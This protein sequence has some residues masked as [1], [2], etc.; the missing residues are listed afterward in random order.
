[1][2]KVLSYCYVYPLKTGYKFKKKKDSTHYCFK[3]IDIVVSLS[4]INYHHLV[5]VVAMV[6]QW[7][8]MTRLVLL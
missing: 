2:K 1:M 7:D 4:N 3:L 5:P 6:G 8:R